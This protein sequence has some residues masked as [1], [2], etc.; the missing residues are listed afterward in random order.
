[1]QPQLVNNPVKKYRSSHL[2]GIVQLSG[3]VERQHGSKQ[4]RVSVEKV[5]VQLVVVEELLLVGAEQ[6]VRVLVER[7]SPGLEAMSTHV[8]SNSHV[9]SHHRPAVTTDRRR[10]HRTVCD[11]HPAD[12]GRSHER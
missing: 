11:W 2:L 12:R 6:R 4:F 9:G 8:D 5:L 1:M 10:G 3:A 7:V